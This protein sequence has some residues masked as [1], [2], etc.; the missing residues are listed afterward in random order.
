MANGAAL[1]QIRRAETLR[2]DRPAG[3]VL[4]QAR[5]DWC[6]SNSVNVD[7]V[8]GAIHRFELRNTYGAALSVFAISLGGTSYLTLTRLDDAHKQPS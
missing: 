2:F 7:L 6:L 3:C 4:L 5:I 8:E 1:G